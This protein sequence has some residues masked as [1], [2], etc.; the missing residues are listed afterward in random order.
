M[1]VLSWLFYVA[2]LMLQTLFGGFVLSKLW[3]WFIV[4]KFSMLPALNYLDCVGLTLTANFLMTPMILRQ[5]EI[6]TQLGADISL[7]TGIIRSLIIMVVL[8]P[9][10]LGVGFFWHLFV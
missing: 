2:L 10:A 8:Y 5:A 4:T 9:V 3:Q 1:K 6:G 7:P